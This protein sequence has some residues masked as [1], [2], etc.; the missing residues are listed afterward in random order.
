MSALHRDTKL[1][2]YRASAAGQLPIEDDLDAHLH[3]LRITL[4]AGSTMGEA[5]LTDDLGI[6]GRNER[7][8]DYAVAENE[9]RDIEIWTLDA[10]DNRDQC[11][12]W[13]TIVE[14]VFRLTDRGEEQRQYIARILP[15]HT[16]DPIYGQQVWP[17]DA[18]EEG[19]PVLSLAHY[20]WE[21]NPEVDGRIIANSRIV[22][23]VVPDVDLPIFLDPEST[24]TTTATDYHGGTVAT[25]YV[26]KAVLMAMWTLNADERYIA[27]IL[28]ADLSTQLEGP[29]LAALDLHNLTVPRGLFLAQALDQILLPQ[30]FNWCLDFVVTDDAGAKTQQPTFRFFARGYGDPLELNCYAVG[31]AADASQ[32]ELSYLELHYDSGPIYNEVRAFGALIERECTLTLYRTWD[33]ESDGEGQDS[34]PHNPIDRIWAANEGGDY[35]ELRTE[36]PVGPQV[37]DPGTDYVWDA[38][39][40]Y[41]EPCLT[42]QDD[43]ATERRPPFLEYSTDGST[44][45]PVPVE[46]GWRVLSNQ[47]GV[48]FTGNPIP[49][50]ILES[51][52]ELRLTCTVRGDQRLEG[53]ALDTSSPLSGTNPLFIDVSDRFFSRARISSGDSA[54]VLSGDADLQDDQTAIDDFAAEILADQQKVRLTGDPVLRGINTSYAIGDLIT[55]VNGRE[56]SLNRRP[57]SGVTEIDPEYPQVIGITYE[58]AFPQRT[59]LHLNGNDR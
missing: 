39:R 7:I 21:F 20:D 25:W 47:I 24:R 5:V 58:C 15:W 1:A 59:I 30:R 16:G 10:S 6:N 12:F 56:I 17:D 23:G 52:T 9:D 26:D 42:Y 35:S 53:V 2:V 18:E 57:P 49:S 27:N 38:K 45:E 41:A 14:T 44:W 51:E 46:W 50:E 54:S 34:D 36:I 29:G 19:A 32:H 4:R 55:L 8:E 22:T 11:L 43:D 48:H 3:P 28:E 33:S 40:R 13:G 31:D 37:I